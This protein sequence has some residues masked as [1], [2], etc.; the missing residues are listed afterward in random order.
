M[1]KKHRMVGVL[2]PHHIISQLALYSLLT[3]ITRSKIVRNAI[4]HWY[5]CQMNT[6][7]T[8]RTALELAKVFQIEWNEQP[9]GVHDFTEHVEW[10][11]N[12]LLNRGVEQVYVDLIIENLKP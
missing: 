6:T 12:N 8:K 4:Q 7:S 11:K 9:A 1:D 2:I 5:N 10:I 3:K